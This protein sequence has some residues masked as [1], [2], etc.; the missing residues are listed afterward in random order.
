LTYGLLLKVA[1]EQRLALQLFNTLLFGGTILLVYGLGH[2][3]HNRETGFYAALLLFGLPFL[4]TQIPQVLNDGH[5][6]FCLVATIYT[7]IN[8]LRRG[9]PGRLSLGALAL[10]A[11]LLVKYSAWLALP[12]LPALLW[13]FPEIA[14]RERVRRALL[15][16]G[17]GGLLAGFFL[18]GKREVILAQLAL[19]G[20]YQRAGLQH[21]QESWLSTFFFQSHPFVLLLALAGGVR[22]FRLRNRG[23]LALLLLPLLLVVMDV[24]RSRYLLPYLPLLTLLAAYGLQAFA[25]PRLKR[26][27]ATG[28]VA[29]SGLILLGAY[30]PFFKSTSLMNLL[31]AGAY[32]DRLQPAGAT[33]TVLPQSGASGATSAAVPLLD[34]YTGVRLQVD[35]SWPSQT[36]RPTGTY[37]T[38]LEFTR[39][40]PKPGFYRPAATT[41]DTGIIIAGSPFSLRLQHERRAATGVGL[42]REFTLSSPAFRYKT[43]VA[44]MQPPLAAAP[45]R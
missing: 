26:G 34:L 43:L 1:G 30:L 33:V 27:L 7:F 3:L 42:W 31:Q 8:G 11:L 45:D 39:Q 24:E 38:S 2:A 37:A 23:F 14:L 21:W 28:I 9:D 25:E 17:G 40:L 36:A 15:I 29:A 44:V 32:L 16:F 41:P 20:S 10:A 13:C 5:V 35:Q 18:V 6:M 19:L 4:L 22:A 12:L